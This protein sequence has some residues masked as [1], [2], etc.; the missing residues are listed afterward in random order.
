[1]GLAQQFVPGIATN[2]HKLVIDVCDLSLWIGGGQ[3]IRAITDGNLALGHWFVYAHL[4]LL[5]KFIRKEST[6]VLRAAIS[7]GSKQCHPIDT[8]PTW[9]MSHI[10][11]RA[12]SVPYAFKNAGGKSTIGLQTRIPNTA[13]LQTRVIL[14]ANRAVTQLLALP[15]RRH[16]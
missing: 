12:L 2:L 11:Y 1:M 10:N 15:Q 8:P 4:A 14:K 5:I 16:F 9:F 6:P 7:Y 13:F 3:Y